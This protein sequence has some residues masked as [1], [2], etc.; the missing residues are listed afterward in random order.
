[1]MYPQAISHGNVLTFTPP[2]FKQSLN[3]KFPDSRLAVCEKCKKNFK[4]RDMCR[5]RNCHTSAPWTTAFI[6]LTLDESCTDAEGKYID[7]PLTVRMVQWT[8][9]QVK[10]P[11]D[12]KTPVCSACKKTNRTRSFCRERHKHRNLPWCTVYVLLSALDSADP[13]TVVADPSKPVEEGKTASGGTGGKKGQSESDE[14]DATSPGEASA[15]E[16]KAS[17]IDA[18]NFKPNIGEAAA[19]GDEGDDVNNI[20]PSRTFL[21]KVNCQGTTI[22][23]LELNEFD[24]D[25]SLR[26]PQ[27]GIADPAYVMPHPMPGD[28]NQ[29]THYYHPSYAVQQG[30]AMKNQQQ[31]FYHMQQQQY[32]WQAHQQYGRVPPQHAQSP[33][34]QIDISSSPVPVTAGEAAAQQHKRHLDEGSDLSPPPQLHG[35]G[36]PPPPGQQWML[37]QQMYQAQLPPVG[38]PHYPPRALGQSTDGG[39]PAPGGPGR[40]YGSPSTLQ[41]NGE[42]HESKRQRRS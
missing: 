36:H 32:A 29:H 16:S 4:T 27:Q 3:V 25:Q 13:S 33:P 38:P 20:A 42:E 26:L 22:H 18:E 12:P 5:V 21:A 11:F 15:A 41:G 39:S 17:S 28:P 35:G 9:Y 34:G 10:T 2:G 24:G 23:W 8:P 19:E 40:E 7:K 30:A 31:Y 1:M 37:Y 6:C 14:K